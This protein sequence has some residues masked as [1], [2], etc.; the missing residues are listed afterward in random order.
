MDFS[1]SVASGSMYRNPEME[2]EA[3]KLQ[4]EFEALMNTRDKP[5]ESEFWKANQDTDGF[6]EMMTDFYS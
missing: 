3:A 4:A 2:Q 1:R 5:K 6:Y